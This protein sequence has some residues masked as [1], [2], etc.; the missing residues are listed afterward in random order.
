MAFSVNRTF[1]SEN[2]AS[3]GDII[4][5]RYE[6]GYWNELETRLTGSD[7]EYYYYQAVSPGFSS[8][9]IALPDVEEPEPEQPVVVP[10]D[11]PVNDT[12]E[13]AEPEQPGNASVEELPEPTPVSPDAVDPTRGAL[14]TVIIVVAGLTA[15]LLYRRSRRKS[16]YVKGFV[17][18][19]S[20]HE[21]D[22]TSHSE[23]HSH[24]TKHH[25]KHQQQHKDKDK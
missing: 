5:G 8:F 19:K 6:N 10:V 24:S 13:P 14:V 7:A 4:L 22:H 16:Q 17:Y 21:K 20:S 12:V 11:E 3:T 1:I 25:P 2:N 9:V 15:Y 18:P 23:A